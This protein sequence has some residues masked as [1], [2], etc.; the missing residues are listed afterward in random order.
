VPGQKGGPGFGKLYAFPNFHPEK[1]V[2][3]S[4]SFFQ[5]DRMETEWSHDGKMALLLTQSEVDK[6]G[7]SYYG[8]QQLHFIAANGD[9]AMVQLAKDGPIY[10]IGWS[11][12]GNEFFVVYG[13]MPAKATLFSH[14]CEKLFDFGT[15]PRNTALFNPQGSMLLLG[16]FGNL[17]GAIEVNNRISTGNPFV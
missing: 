12:T 17:R 5:A 7:A 8:K 11:P 3:A 2:V 6:T 1:D 16:G 13:Y 10:S 9:T 15:G 14:K 4:K